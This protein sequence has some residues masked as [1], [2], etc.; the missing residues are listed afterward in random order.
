MDADIAQSPATSPRI[1]LEVMRS[2]LS[3]MILA[4]LVEGTKTQTELRTWL[5]LASGTSL[6]HHLSN[7]RSL[8]LLARRRSKRERRRV[9]YG[10]SEAGEGLVE[11]I[12]LVQAWV[13]RHHTRRGELS[14][15]LG[16]RAFNV[17]AD[18][19]E[20]SV[21][22]TLLSEPRSRGD[23]LGGQLA[24]ALGDEKLHRTLDV[25]LGAGLLEARGHRGGNRLHLTEWCRIG[26][27]PLAATV[28]WERRYLAQGA[29]PVITRDAALA[30]EATL[31]LSRPEY[32]ARGTCA[33]T[34]EARGERARAVWARVAEGRVRDGGAGTPPGSPDAWARGDVERWFAAVL[35][36][37]LSGLRLGGRTEL[38]SSV[39]G[40]LHHQLYVTEEPAR[41]GTHTYSGDRAD[42]RN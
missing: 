9:D 2:D 31:P 14:G 19:W 13:G 17:F 32:G 11:V 6:N 18:A 36:G 27:G 12:G 42:S 8:G 5:L 26:F 24:I 23:L 21:L 25:L 15:P 35:D 28:R 33:F 41:M 29:T 40:G 34:I 16:W 37:D 22:G 20:L 38:A 30:L 3:R 39:L 1:G 10:L 7:L 4:A